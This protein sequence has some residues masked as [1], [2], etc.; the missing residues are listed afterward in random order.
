MRAAVALGDIPLLVV[1]SLLN[2]LQ[3]DSVRAVAADCG[4]IVVLGSAKYVDWRLLDGHS[5]LLID[6][7]GLTETYFLLLILE[8]LVS[9]LRLLK[10]LLRDHRGLFTSVILA[11][12]LVLRL[13]SLIEVIQKSNFVLD[14]LLVLDR[15]IIRKSTLQII[16][17][18]I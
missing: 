12:L 9:A 14:F 11:L 13:L 16:S 4:P 6:S 3:L 8:G 15:S 7:L 5:L 17:Y 18:V 1:A 10:Y 2:D